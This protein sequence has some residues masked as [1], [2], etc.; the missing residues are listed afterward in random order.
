MDTAVF[1]KLIAE[2]PGSVARIFFAGIGEPLAHPDIIRMVRQAKGAGRRVELISN[3]M[4]LSRDVAAELVAAGL[5]TLWISLDSTEVES[6]EAIRAGADFST[7]MENIRGFN[8]LR[9]YP[10]NYTPRYARPK[11]ELGVSFVLMKSNLEQ[12]SKLL[13]MAGRLGISR[14]KA[15]HLIPYDV[16]QVS[17]AVYSD[18]LDRDMYSRPGMVT[19]DVDIP[20]LDVADMKNILPFMADPGLSFSIMNTPLHIKQGQC[21]FITEDIAFVR[22][23]GAVCPCMSLLHESTVYQ[24]GNR[25]IVGRK[26]RPCSYGSITEQTLSQIWQGADYAAFRERA[27]NASFS[28]CARCSPDMCNYIEGNEADCYNNPFPTCGACLWAQGLVQCP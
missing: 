7:I 11:V 10:Y 3:G 8:R 28:P 12:F 22:Q 2:L 20:H 5:D 16:S 25:R 6:F 21:R 13:K 4:L 17:Q 19:A 15:S 14:I 1:D 9:F 26:I 23:D 18:I 27:A 24:G